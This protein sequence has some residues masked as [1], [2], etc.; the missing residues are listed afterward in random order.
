DRLIFN[1]IIPNDD[2]CQP[3]GDGWMYEIDPTDG[4]RLEFSV[5][6]LDH[7]GKFGDK[8]DL[9]TDGSIVSGIRVGMGSGIVARG[10]TKY[11]SNTKG[12]VTSVKNNQHPN[13]GRRTWR[14]LR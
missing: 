4:S 10:D 1:T 5:F 12:K 3:D 13:I 8:N 11:H 9:A 7:D 2:E 6:D 14:Q